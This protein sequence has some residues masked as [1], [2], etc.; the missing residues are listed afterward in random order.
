MMTVVPIDPPG[1][2][3]VSHSPSLSAAIQEAADLSQYTAAQLSQT[4]DWVVGYAAGQSPAQ[5][6]AAVGATS[7]GPANLLANSVVFAFPATVSAAQAADKLATLSGKTFDFPLVPI[8]YAPNSFTPAGSLFPQEWQLQNTGQTGGTVGAD[9][10]VLPAWAAGAL[11]K[12]VV[13]GVIDTGVYGAHPDLASNY[14]PDLSYN[15]LESTPNAS[16]PAPLGLEDNHGTAVAGV[17]AGSGLTTDGTVGVAPQAQIAGIRAIGGPIT[18]QTLAQ[19]LELHNQQ[20]QVYN[21]S[22]GPAVTAFTGI[23]VPSDPLLLAAM[24]DGAQH[25]RNGLG[26]IYVFA[27]GN[28]AGAQSDVNY[29]GEASSRFAIAVTGADDF[30]KQTTYAVPGAANLVA[31]PT[32]HNYQGAPDERGIPTTDVVDATD[33]N[34]L[35]TLAPSYLTNDANGFNG[36]S[37][38]APVVSG[39]VALMLSVNPKL[40]YRDVQMILAETATQNDPTDPGWSGNTASFTNDGLTF[41][42]FHINNK[43]GFGTVNAAAAVALAKQWSPLPAENV[44][45]SPLVAVNQPI[46]DG[47]SAG[48]SSTITFSG[49]AL[50]LEHVE[51]TLTAT[52]P[53]QG[54]LTVILTSPNGTQSV[55]ALTRSTDLDPTTG[56][57]VPNYTSYTFTSVR[58]WGEMSTGTWT[59]QV[60][61]RSPNGLAG[62][63]DT[64]QMHLYGTTDYPPIA[65]DFSVTTPGSTPASIGM[66]A[67]TYDFLTNSAAG[68]GEISIA[69]QPQHG[70]LTYDSSTGLAIYSPVAGFSGV[71]TFTYFVTDAQG[72]KSR[73]AT[74]SIN[75]GFLALQPTAVD[76][77]GSVALGSSTVIDVLTNDSSPDGTLVPASVTIVTPPQFGVVSVNPATGAVTYTPGNAFLLSDSFQY[78]V[79]DSHGMVSNVA[80]VTI[81]RLSGA[82]TAVN[83]NATTAKNQN[84]SINVLGND[85]QGAPD[86]PLDP[87]KVSIITP[88]QNGS[89][90]VDPS[91]GIVTYAPK[92]NFF[93][94]DNFTYTVSDL[95]GN[96]SNAALVSITVSSLGAPVALNHE[97]VLVPGFDTV[98]GIS[99]LDNPTNSGPLVV[100]LVQQAALGTVALNPDGTFRYNQGPNFAGLDAFTYQV[101]DGSHVS[102]TGMIRLVSPQFHYVEKLY[103]SILGRQGSDADILNWVGDMSRGASRQDVATA[104]LNSSE[105]RGDLVN[106]IYQQLLG[107]PA[108]I[109]GTGFWVGQMQFGLSA[110]QV[111]AAIAGSGEYFARH[112]STNAGFVAGLYHDLL[113]RTPGPAEIANWT[114]AVSGG[115]S[116]SDVALQFLGSNEYRGNLINSYY[117]AYLGHQ[118][119]R[120]GM[121]NWLFLFQ[122]G[123]PRTAI[124]AGILGSNEYFNNL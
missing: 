9:A 49:A 118:A 88:A 81:N 91:T 53:Q 31:A 87:T 27:A 1:Q 79:T 63:F 7:L 113:G 114:S 80:T 8:E 65:R 85:Q 83:D 52:H 38:A 112:G 99:A 103:Q 102:N 67:N 39:V 120:G 106:A 3:D 122:L 32:G 62:S 51:V 108:D 90:S 4:Y 22:W 92:A 33:A 84:I 119:D 55:L 82:P 17:A 13:I 116:P 75:V 19:A 15:F 98:R 96:V 73:A 104:F 18:S 47:T 105:Y 115:I 124:Q 110:E 2:I 59:L 42:P 78:D 36:T 23:A 21:N 58:D 74:V 48:V 46:P 101:N 69:S 61:D 45:S 123:Y 40:S 121:N 100:Q 57:P 28:G 54:D 50:H 70:T 66:T 71:D 111:M 26:N 11:G 12:G 68:P 60:S 86:I 89:L 64:W 24:Q 56:K 35:P 77:A 107:R 37:S 43:Y 29:A 117:Q 20:I 72:N 6:A 14:R 97:F 95:A 16:P 44:L 5:M 94:T 30:G 25:G 76:D 109:G 10:N 41:T 93:G 34:G